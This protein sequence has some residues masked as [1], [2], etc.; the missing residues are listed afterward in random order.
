M[1]R[2]WRSRV[3]TA[4]TLAVATSA[5]AGFDGSGLSFTELVVGGGYIDVQSLDPFGSDYA[6]FIDLS[7]P[8]PGSFLEISAADPAFGSFHSGVSFGSSNNGV[9]LF[10]FWSEVNALPFGG[11]P[12]VD[13]AFAGGRISFTTEVPVIVFLIGSVQA[14]ET[15]RGFFGNYFDDGIEDWF[16]EASDN[17]AYLEIEL[18]PGTYSFAFGSVTPPVGGSA[19]FEG[20]IA[21]EVVPAPGVMALLGAASLLARR[22]RR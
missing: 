14:S 10:N 2:S 17:P 22:R 11:V 12:D 15:G 5:Q 21:I 1:V 20:T 6:D 19:S 7:D 13:A 4:A 18:G 9:A 8:S 3:A 16:F